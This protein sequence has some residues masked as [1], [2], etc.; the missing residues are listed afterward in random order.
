MSLFKNQKKSSHKFSLSLTPNKIRKLIP[1]IL[2]LAL[3]VFFAFSHTKLARLDVHEY[4]GDSGKAIIHG[5]YAPGMSYIMPVTSISVAV[6]QYHLSDDA[7]HFTLM[8]LFLLVLTLT[9]C[10]GSFIADSVTGFLS[11]AL[12]AVG[13]LWWRSDYN[14]V[15]WNLDL[16][17]LIFTSILI[18]ICITLALDF[19]K[20][21]LKSRVFVG[22]F[23]GA[24]LL[25]RTS[26]IFLPFV[27]L[28][29]KITADHLKR[30]KKSDFLKSAL[31]YWPIVV[32]PFCF[33]S[34]WSIVNFVSYD[35]FVFFEAGRAKGQ[36]ILGALG[37]IGTPEGDH[38]ALTGL[39]DDKNVMHWAMSEVLHHPFRYII[40]FFRRV[41]FILMRCPFLSLFSLAAFVKFRKKPEYKALGII[42]AYFLL[43]HCVIAVEIRY[44]MPLYAVMVPIAFSLLYLF[45][46]NL[47][48]QNHKFNRLCLIFAV[49]PIIALYG[50]VF[51]QLVTYP[52]R[53]NTT[54][55][56]ITAEKE[57]KKYPKDPWLMLELAGHYSVSKK[58]NEAFKLLDNYTR[59]TDGV[60]YQ[61]VAIYWSAGKHK[62]A[63]ELADKALEFPRGGFRPFNLLKSLI[64][65]ETGDIASAKENMET[66]A[67]NFYNAWSLI[68]YVSSKHDEEIQRHLRIYDRRFL[69]IVLDAMGRLPV[70]RQEKIKSKLYLVGVDI[71]RPAW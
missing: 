29:F 68:R 70:K 48:L 30:K 9:F 11:A 15:F 22:T 12:I 10:L 32:V 26:L 69:R 65:L 7:R 19:K 47:K 31:K 13:I 27:I 64:Q 59:I 66:A 2:F 58:F 50:F 18:L 5:L 62:R 24:S 61:H 40:G 60:S 46:E 6:F 17:N 8:F 56:K 3:V 38:M 34:F 23:I 20:S 16:E 52:H 14:F 35:K 1:V 45:T 63:L 49:V 28:G 54:N 53:Q 51:L 4:K 44:F 42:S 39:Y 71:D 25:I 43:I 67:I 36:A 57:L 33:L 41:W 21:T 55:N 37:V